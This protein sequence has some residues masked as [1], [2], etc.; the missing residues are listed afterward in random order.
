M[1]EDE[2]R[3]LN[4]YGTKPKVDEPQGELLAYQ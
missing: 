4:L 1:K 3:Q 2:E